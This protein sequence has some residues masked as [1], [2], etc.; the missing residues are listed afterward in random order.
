MIFQENQNSS[1]EHEEQV[2]ER[3]ERNIKGVFFKKRHYMEFF[4]CF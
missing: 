2:E 4:C 1:T 3:Q